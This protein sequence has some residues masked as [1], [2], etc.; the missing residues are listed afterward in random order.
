MLHSRPLSIRQ[1]WLRAQHL[2]PGAIGKE[3]LMEGKP[4]WMEP[5]DRSVR[6]RWRSCSIYSSD[7]IHTE[8]GVSQSS[9]IHC[10]TRSPH[11]R[12]PLLL[13]YIV[14]IHPSGQ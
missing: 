11:T 8:L 7:V 4:G 3:V 9:V 12:L 10:L 1:A 5:E 14:I 13:L 2:P 6:L